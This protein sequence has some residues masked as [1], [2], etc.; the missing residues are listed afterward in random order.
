M[1]AFDKSEPFEI[2]ICCWKCILIVLRSNV[3]CIISY[4]HVNVLVAICKTAEFL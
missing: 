3:Q 4:D 2:W 1:L